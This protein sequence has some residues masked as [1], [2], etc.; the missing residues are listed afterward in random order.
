MTKRGVKAVSYSPVENEP[1]RRPGRPRSFDREAALDRAVEMFWADGYGGVDMARLA[2][3]VGVTKP[4]LYHVFGDKAAL[5]LKALHR[6]GQTHAS[7][8][9][10]AFEAEPNIA[11]A[12]TAFCEAAVTTTTANGRRGCMMACTA[13]GPAGNMAVVRDFLAQGQAT[14]AER[15]TRRFKQEM[16]AGHLSSVVP[17]RA[18]AQLLVD[19]MQGL[20]LRARTGAAGVELLADARSYLPLLLG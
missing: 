7:S 19:L 1:R 15:L 13:A 8:A 5:F 2:R 11:R 16:D 17:A 4:S 14:A 9:L 18:R 12:V 3:A 6:Y 20:A 10:A